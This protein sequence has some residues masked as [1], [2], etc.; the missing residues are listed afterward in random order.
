MTGGPW[1]TYDRDRLRA[2]WSYPVGRTIVEASLHAAGVH[3]LS[4]DFRMHGGPAPD[5]ILLKATRYRDLGNTYYRPRGTPERSRC[6]FAI[7]AVPSG[8]RADAH[9]VLTTGGGL[10]RACAWLAATE[11]AD[12]TWLYKSHSWTA[13]LL[14]GAMHE[15]AEATG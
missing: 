13:Q 12:P 10:D 11:S 15:T 4:L 6:V 1:D 9:A 5:P 7:H 2:G 8:V 3:L 14:N